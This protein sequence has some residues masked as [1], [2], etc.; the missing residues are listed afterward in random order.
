MTQS[1]FGDLGFWATDSMTSGPPPA[2]GQGFSMSTDEMRSLLTK[3]EALRET[4]SG[5]FQNALRLSQA[6]PPA[7]EPASVNAVNAANGVNETGR[8]YRGHLQFQF[9]YLSE[10][11]VRMKQALGIIK[12]TEQQAADTTKTIGAAE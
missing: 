6:K 10:L 5:Q 8:Y 2:G 7:D 12:E 3:A 11:I 1:H 9:D 4:I